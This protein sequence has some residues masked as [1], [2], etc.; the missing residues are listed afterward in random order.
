MAF[1]G[2]L[3]LRFAH[4][5]ES[6]GASGPPWK[7]KPKKLRPTNHMKPSQDKKPCRPCSGSNCTNL[8]VWIGAWT[9][10]IAHPFPEVW[11]HCWR[12]LVKCDG[13]WCTERAA[14]Q[15][16]H[17]FLWTKAPGMPYSEDATLESEV[18][19]DM[20]V[21]LS[22]RAVPC[23]WAI[24][25]PR[26]ELSS[27]FSWRIRTQLSC[28]W[29]SCK[30]E[31]KMPN[32]NVTFSVR[33]ETVETEKKEIAT[34]C[35]EPNDPVWIHGWIS[36]STLHIE[37]KKKICTNV[38]RILASTTNS[39]HEHDCR[40]QRIKIQSAFPAKTTFDPE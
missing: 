13:H 27:A 5:F 14:Y 28:I 3:P 36:Y 2:P 31:T 29:N 11:L 34:E 19:G 8:I 35:L 20:H 4:S 32:V 33:S 38:V 6:G 21:Y 15:Y 12:K 9:P 18:R 40:L 26:S 10:L 24:A 22:S 30:S 25:W 37:T 16:G 7:R 23:T 1:S 39:H 17:Q